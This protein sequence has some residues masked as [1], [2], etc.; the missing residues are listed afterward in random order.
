MTNFEPIKEKIWHAA[1]NDD[2]TSFDD[3]C[4]ALMKKVHDD[5]WRI[6]WNIMP[7]DINELVDMIDSLARNAHKMWLAAMKRGDAPAEDVSPGEGF[8][9]CSK[10]IKDELQKLND[11]RNEV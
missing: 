1:K 2:K 7:K 5:W 3:A 10:L 11:M 6:G 4:N 8:A 9:L